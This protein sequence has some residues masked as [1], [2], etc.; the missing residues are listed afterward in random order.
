[1]TDPESPAPPDPRRRRIAALGVALAPVAMGFHV[2]GLE[3]GL[4]VLATFAFPVSAIWFA[5]QLA[6]TNANLMGISLVSVSARQ[7]RTIGWVALVLG[8]LAF[9]VLSLPYAFPRA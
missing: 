8:A 6:A 2:G 4:A 7:I 1:M 9:L 3:I 5:D